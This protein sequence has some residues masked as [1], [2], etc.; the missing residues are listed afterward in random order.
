MVA[1]SLKAELVRWLRVILKREVYRA[2][3]SM[4]FVQYIKYIACEQVAGKNSANSRLLHAKY[5]R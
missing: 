5:R 3:E 4:K 1:V 2:K